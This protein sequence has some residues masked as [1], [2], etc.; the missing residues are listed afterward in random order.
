V[1]RVIA[2]S[3]CRNGSGEFSR[4]MISPVRFYVGSAREAP[5]AAVIKAGDLFYVED[6]VSYCGRRAGQ[7]RFEPLFKNAT[8]WQRGATAAHPAV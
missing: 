3:A 5:N 8:S 4:W 1:L 7:I 2:G 6:T